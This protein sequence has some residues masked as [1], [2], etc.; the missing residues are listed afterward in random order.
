MRY[1]DA[2]IEALKAPN[3]LHAYCTAALGNG[4]RFGNVWKYPC[5]YGAHTRLKLEVAERNGCGV[6][7]C[8]ACQQGGTVFNI[9]AAVRGL[10]PHR[11]FLQCVEE[12]AAQT[13]YLLTEQEDAPHRH[14]KRSPSPQRRPGVQ[15]APSPPPAPVYLPP[16]GENEALAAVRHAA[17]HPEELEAHAAALGLPADVLHY[18]TN[19]EEAAPL[20]LLGLTPA[21]LLLYVYTDTDEAGRVRVQ[22][23][24]TRNA[25][26]KEPR[27]IQRGS[28]AGLWGAGALRAAPCR[29][30][31]ITEGESDCL[32]LRAAVWAWLT[33]WA[34]D[35]PES[36][37]EMAAFPLV[38]A[39]PDAG[40]FRDEWAIPLRGVDVILAI[41]AD[42]AGQ[43]GATR[44]AE[45]LR[46]A[47]VSRIFTWTPPAP[48]K[49]ARA[50]LDP[51]RP[52]LLAE[53]L[54]THKTLLLA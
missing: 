14:A 4:R 2:D 22:S 32:A 3:V 12:V 52:W 10:D 51:A 8:R 34:H 23:T 45:T 24:K 31:I 11:D 48:H 49:D 17:A 15:H 40:T 1:S 50:A 47:G 9:A 42:E 30:V 38:L 18:H 53:H 36:L 46:A 7:L 16:D 33:H 21:G 41:D 26:G 39:K 43:K 28:K 37:P 5:P 27:F 19:M 44:T 25:P 29:R 35:E 54:M 6:A 13:G 20:G